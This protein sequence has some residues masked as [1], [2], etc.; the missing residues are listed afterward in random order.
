M[1][2]RQPLATSREELNTREL[3]EAC[4]PRVEAWVWRASLTVEARGR[5]GSRVAVKG[6]SRDCGDELE[7]QSPSSRS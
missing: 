6:L 7:W 5:T 3:L 1:G 2:V 4:R